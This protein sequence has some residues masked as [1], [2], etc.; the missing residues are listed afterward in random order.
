[1]EETRRDSVSDKPGRNDPCYCGSGKKYKQCHLPADRQA[2]NERHELAEAGRWLRRDFLKFARQE[3]FAASFAAALPL[4][5]RDLYTVENAEQMSENEAMRFIDWFVFDYRPEEGQR[6]IDVYRQERFDDL[7]TAQQ[8]V[9]D[10]WV[11]APPA[12]AYE[13][14]GY[15][16][17]TLHLRDF[18]T[19]ELF[20]VY[21]PAGHGVVEEGDLLLGRLVPLVGQL[22]F[23]TVA[24]YLPQDE[25]AD[26]A[27]KLQAA[28]A[29]DAEGH[30]G[31]TPADFMRR[32]GHLIIHHALDQ[33]EL[34]GRPPVAA[35]DP[36]RPKD[37][38][39][40]AAQKIRKLSRR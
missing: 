38:A 4:Y 11:D 33:A 31:A 20:D 22:E 32:R 13:L 18:L 35:S 16:G 23:S 39:R 9:L 17:Q 6:L 21:E 30:P 10:T 3:Q 15:D 27:E 40:Q 5:W 24:A 28:Q 36:N 26:L 37:L 14:L 34:K 1:M 29:A 8:K 12:G 7:S 25:I 2:E 19:N